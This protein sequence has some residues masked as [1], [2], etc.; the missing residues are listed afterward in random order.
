M[1]N[2]RLI[3]KTN[4]PTKPLWCARCCVR[5]APSERHAIKAGKTYHEVCYAKI[6]NKD[7]SAR[8]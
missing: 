5:I 8:N 1:K 7:R 6:H 4:D 2:L 3:T